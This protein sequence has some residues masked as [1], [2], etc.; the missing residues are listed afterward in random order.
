VQPLQKVLLSEIGDLSEEVRRL[1]ADLDRTLRR[2]GG[3]PAGE[4]APS[5]DVFETEETI[6]VVLDVPGVP[7]EAL[8]ILIKGSVVV[9]AGEKPPPSRDSG[10]PGSSY[11]VVEREFG[12]F[13]RAIRITRAFDTGHARASLHAGELRLV[14]PKLH[15][16][17]GRD[18]LIAIELS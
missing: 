17:R 1:F 9:V 18:I 12:R 2:L 15:E 13:A 4:W 8:R 5:L 11:H 16:R 3:E 14:L 7:L 6:E 10:I